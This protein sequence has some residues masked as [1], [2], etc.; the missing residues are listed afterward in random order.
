MNMNEVGFCKRARCL[1]AWL[2]VFVVLLFSL[3]AT[4]LYAE[5][6]VKITNCGVDDVY[7]ESFDWDDAVTLVAYDSDT[8]K[9]GDT[10]TFSCVKSLF[11]SD[12]PGCKLIVKAGTSGGFWLGD[13]SVE[14]GTYTA[15]TTETTSSDGCAGTITLCLKEQDSCSSD[16]SDNTSDCT[17]TGSAYDASLTCEEDQM[18]D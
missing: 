11:D 12:A 15:T 1:K 17:Q 16:D 4:N 3:I 5:G 2:T 8:L 6:S 9:V 7:V 13:W 18:L 14:N 10:I